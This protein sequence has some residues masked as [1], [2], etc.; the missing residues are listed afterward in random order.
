MNNILLEAPHSITVRFS[1]WEEYALV[2]SGDYQKLEKFGDYL[3]IR[4]EPKAWWQPSLSK[5]EWKKANAICDG[6]G[7]WLFNSG[8]SREW[9]LSYQ[10]LRF[11]ARCNENSKHVGVFAEQAPHWEWLAFVLKKKANRQQFKKP[12]H[13]LNVFGYTGIASLVAAAHG[14]MVTHIDGSKPTL[15]WARVNAE[16]CSTFQHPIRFMLDDAHK[17]IKREIRRGNR[18][19]AIMLDPP[20]FG[21]GPKG[22]V[23]KAEKNLVG[24]LNDCRALLSDKPQF[25]ILTM[26]AI[27]ASAIMLGNFLQHMMINHHG[28]L[29]IGELAIKPLYGNNILPMAIFA[30]WLAEDLS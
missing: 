5:N 11:F 14:A 3:I 20:S 29:E 25:V 2:D 18:Y 28:R 10:S 13:F 16:L 21:R 26:Y 12:C 1:E 15:S 4:H 30:R 23:W 8:F 6:E 22:E 24:L 9:Q 19:D 17:F 7:H 27:E